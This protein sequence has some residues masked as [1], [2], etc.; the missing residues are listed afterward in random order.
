MEHAGDEPSIDIGRE[1]SHD[2]AAHGVDPHARV[3][4]TSG[5]RDQDELIPDCQSL[6]DYRT[7]PEDAAIYYSVE[8]RR[9][10]QYHG[11]GAS[12]CTSRSGR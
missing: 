5:I 9:I 11:H 6:H 10:G 2:I 3:V 12:L 4:H 8:L 7:F 1:M